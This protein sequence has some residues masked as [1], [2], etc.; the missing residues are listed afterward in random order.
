MIKLKYTKRQWLSEL[1]TRVANDRSRVRWKKSELLLLEVTWTCR[2]GR[3]R[4]G[5]CCEPF[6]T[7]HRSLCRLR[8]CH[9][10]QAVVQVEL[11]RMPWKIVIF[12][13]CLA[14]HI[15]SKALEHGWRPD[16]TDRGP[17]WIASPVI[18]NDHR[19]KRVEMIAL[20]NWSNFLASATTTI[21]TVMSVGGCLSRCYH[22]TTNKCVSS[23][24]VNISFETT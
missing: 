10:H 8:P 2:S 1:L 6:R 14:T 15:L 5:D 11:N 24:G 20:E 3:R 19:I 23:T 21:T 16:A 18:S 7:L 17:H 12:L 22:I 4:R 13:H 9:R